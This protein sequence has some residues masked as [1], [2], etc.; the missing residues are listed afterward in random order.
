MTQPPGN[1]P[2]GCA[3][4]A[5]TPPRDQLNVLRILYFVYAGLM[6]LGGCFPVFHLAMGLVLLFAP[7]KPAAS[8]D[9]FPIKLFGLFFVVMALIFMALIWTMGVLALLTARNLKQ[10]RRLLFCRVTAGILCAMFPF[11]TAL[12]VTTLIMLSKADMAALFVD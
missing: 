10:P 2:V 1:P 11:G 3:S 7:L 8:S 9:P 5:S 12:G 4:G 6:G